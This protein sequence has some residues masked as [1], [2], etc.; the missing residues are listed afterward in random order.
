MDTFSVDQITDGFLGRFMIFEGNDYGKRKEQEEQH[1]IPERILETTH[2]W[3]KKRAETVNQEIPN[4]NVVPVTDEAKKIFSQFYGILDQIQKENNSVKDALWGR[5]V[6][7][8][9]QFA[10]IYAASVD[11][12]NPVIDADAAHWA[13][14]LVSYL[15]ERKIYLANRHVA[16]SEFDKQQKEMLRYIEECKGTCTRTMLYRRFRKLKKRERE[17]IIENLIETNAIRREFRQQKGKRQSTL[18]FVMNKKPS[19]KTKG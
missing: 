13:Y 18:Y 6:Q 14:D 5:A 2:W 16:D 12:E 19:S 9:R 10:L 17:D 8:A 7:Q 4:P 3:L 11:K 15:I 1:P